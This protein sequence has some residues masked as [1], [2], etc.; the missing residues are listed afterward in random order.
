M[1]L[2][3]VTVAA[4]AALTMTATAG[5]HML[6]P[7][8]NSKLP[9]RAELRCAR[10]NRQHALATIAWVHHQARPLSLL[11]YDAAQQ[12]IL[13]RVVANHRWLY[14]TMTVR[15]EEATHRI[16]MS[17]RPAHYALWLCIHGGEGAWPDD[18][19]NGFYGGLQ[20]TLGWYGGPGHK[21]GWDP[22]I[23]QM[24][25]AEA[26]YRASGYS[27]SWLGGQWPNTSPPCLAYA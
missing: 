18:T 24:R 15:A 3:F 9:A 16:G 11:A 12:L 25:A 21:A 17:D 10:L 20:M 13:A 6:A 22:P 2:T 7:R 19:G 14:R 5:A 26:G 27:R 23:V 1:K 4:V 8:C